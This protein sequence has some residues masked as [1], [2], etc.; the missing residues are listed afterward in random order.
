MFSA[1]KR[2]LLSLLYVVFFIIFIKLL[3]NVIRGQIYEEN[4]DIGK[5]FKLLVLRFLK[6]FFMT[7]CI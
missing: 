4:S 2:K 1:P 5:E 3:R 6:T 7:F